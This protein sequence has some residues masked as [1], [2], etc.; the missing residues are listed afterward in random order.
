MEIGFEA[1]ITENFLRTS[2][3]IYDE[4]QRESKGLVIVMK[5]EEDFIA[6]RN[7][8]LNSETQSLLEGSYSVEIAW[9]CLLLSV[10][11]WE[12]LSIVPS[13]SQDFLL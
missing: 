4:T 9:C 2:R 3:F 13:I 1:T 5:D 10:F 12:F 11:V 7:S 6:S 8:A